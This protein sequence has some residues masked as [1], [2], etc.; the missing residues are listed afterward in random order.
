MNWFEFLI[1]YST[2]KPFY[3]FKFVEK[4]DGLELHF[5]FKTKPAPSS[6]KPY[7]LKKNN[8]LSSAP[9]PSLR[10]VK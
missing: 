4:N 6:A 3:L 1:S 10:I 8:D 7:T 2:D 9:G 5:R